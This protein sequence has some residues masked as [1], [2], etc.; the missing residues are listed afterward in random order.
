M[1]FG[2]IVSTSIDRHTP[3]AIDPYE[4]LR[5]LDFQEDGAGRVVDR[6]RVSAKMAEMKRIS[7]LAGTP[8]LSWSRGCAK[9]PLGLA[10]VARLKAQPPALSKP[11]WS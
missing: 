1:L 11:Y 3:E 8:I 10:G 2:Q 7:T 6:A 9:P 4:Y 5:T